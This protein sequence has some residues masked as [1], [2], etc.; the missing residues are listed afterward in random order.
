MPLVNSTAIPRRTEHSAPPNANFGPSSQAITSGLVSSNLIRPV[1]VARPDPFSGTGTINELDMWVFSMESYLQMHSITDQGTR[2]FIAAALLK[3]A[4]LVW[5]QAFVREANVTGVTLT[6]KGFRDGLFANF[7][8]T[9]LNQSAR[10]DIADCK[11]TSSVREY[12]SRFR[13]LSL[14]I[15]DMAAPERLDKFMRGLK[16][17][18]RK[19]LIIREVTTFD[20]ATRLAERLESVLTIANNVSPGTARPPGPYKP[21]IRLN[22]VGGAVV[23]KKLTPEDRQDLLARNACFYCREEGHV[24]SDCPTRPARVS[25][26]NVES[27]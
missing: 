13:T 8:P 18:I 10:N 7:G 24:I 1:D 9:D 2:I 15:N 26:P 25:D 22:A 16:A 27:L 17:N 21:P 11:Q 4:A 20:E 23:R 12:L 14:M 5:F 6:W 3:G 19:E